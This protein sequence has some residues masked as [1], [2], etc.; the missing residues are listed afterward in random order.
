MRCSFSTFNKNPPFH[1]SPSTEREKALCLCIKC[2]NAHLLLKGV[3][4]FRKAKSLMQL[5]SVTEFLQLKNSMSTED[6]E[7]RHPEFSSPKETS[8]YVF[9]KKT[10]TSIKNGVEKSYERTTHLDKT[11][12]VCEIVEQLGESVQV[13]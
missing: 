6:L 11:H 3:N 2:Q 5:N 1:I 4:D 10:E 13:I 9:G 7:K 12:K 8:Y